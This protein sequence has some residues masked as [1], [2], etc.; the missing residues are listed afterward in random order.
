MRGGDNRT[1]KL[2]ASDERMEYDL[3]F[4]RFAGI[5]VDNAVWD[6]SVFSQNRDRLLEGDI[7]AKFPR[8]GAGA[9]QGE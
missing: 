2:L 7:A 1:G 4:R 5:G 6:H 3:R 9:A 8:G